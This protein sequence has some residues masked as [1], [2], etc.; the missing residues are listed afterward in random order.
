[1]RVPS[2]GWGL[3]GSRLTTLLCGHFVRYLEVSRDKWD[4]KEDPNG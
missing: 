4:D 3:D 2:K 1:M